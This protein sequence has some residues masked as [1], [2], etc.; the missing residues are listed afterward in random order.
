MN[1]FEF[2]DPT[3]LTS[4]MLCNAYSGKL[5]TTRLIYLGI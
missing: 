4:Q 2:G 1:V 5:K 3:G